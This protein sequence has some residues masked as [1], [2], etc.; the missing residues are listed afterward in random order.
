MSDILTSPRASRFG[1][2][3]GFRVAGIGSYVPTQVVTNADLARLGCDPEWI[4]ARTGIHERRHAPPDMA[5]SDMAA[6]AG[7]AALAQ[8]GADP[9]QVDMLVVGTFTPDTTIPSTACIVQEQLGLNA[10][11][12]DITAA[13]AGF[14]LSPQ[15]IQALMPDGVSPKCP[16]AANSIASCGV[17]AGARL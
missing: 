14:V 17:H 2:A 5:T 11:A 13:C 6:A 15:V 1:R 9:A 3:V 16:S 12:M 7:R 4:V 8:A 10:P